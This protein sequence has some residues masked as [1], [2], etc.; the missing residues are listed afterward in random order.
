MSEEEPEI[1]L[2]SESTRRQKRQPEE[3]PGTWWEGFFWLFGI[4]F[5]LSS[6]VFLL[7]GNWLYFVFAVA[8]SLQM[9]FT[10]FI[11]KILT[12][13]RWCLLRLATKNE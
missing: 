12:D 7:L 3:P 2:P 6:I 11:V 13:M 1:V 4:L 10:G 8:A 5:S 9:F